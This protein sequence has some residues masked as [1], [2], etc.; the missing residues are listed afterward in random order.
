LDKFVNFNQ[1]L[2]PG[3]FIFQEDMM[4]SLFSVVKILSFNCPLKAH[5]P[6]LSI[7]NFAVHFM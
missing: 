6:H 1:K 7:L 4:K 2:L 3:G 5:P